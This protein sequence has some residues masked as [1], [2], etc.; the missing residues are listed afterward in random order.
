MHSKM[1]IDNILF[2]HPAYKFT[3][4]FKFVNFDEYKNLR[5]LFYKRLYTYNIYKCL[6]SLY[7]VTVFISQ[8]IY[9]YICIFIYSS[10]FLSFHLYT[11]INL[12]IYY[13]FYLYIYLSLFLSIHLSISKNS[14]PHNLS[15]ISIYLSNIYQSIFLSVY[16]SI[17]LGII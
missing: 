14:M 5:F 9:L 13:T 8:S 15:L 6:M 4:N 2:V 7:I 17:Y 12:S 1:A 11:Y 10:I 16:L 3:R